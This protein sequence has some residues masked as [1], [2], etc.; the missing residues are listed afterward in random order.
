MRPAPGGTF[1]GVTGTTVFQFSP[2]AVPPVSTI[3]TF[4]DSAGGQAP[5]GPLVSDLVGDLYGTTEFGGQSGEGTVYELSPP[6]QA[7]AH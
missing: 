6:A 4:S 1:F 7:A 3:Y 2:T 5:Q